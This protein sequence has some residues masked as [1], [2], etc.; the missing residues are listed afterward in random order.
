VT[1]KDDSDRKGVGEFD[2]GIPHGGGVQKLLRKSMGRG[3]AGGKVRETWGVV[4]PH[5]LRM[6]RRRRDECCMVTGPLEETE[7]G[8][9]F[10]VELGEE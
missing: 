4:S 3:R 6:T 2:L 10:I 5:K 7:Q 8:R 1:L 9:S